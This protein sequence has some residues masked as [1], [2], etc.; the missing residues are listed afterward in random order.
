LEAILEELDISGRGFYVR[1]P[2]G[3]VYVYVPLSGGASPP[4]PLLEPSG[5]LYREDGSEFLV[6]VPPASE[7]ARSPELRGMKLESALSYVL[8]DLLATAESIEVAS[9][10]R[11]SVRLRNAKSRV[12]AGR[13]RAVFGSLEASIAACILASM[14]GAA[15]VVDEVEE[16]GDKIIRMEVLKT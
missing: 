2:G 12:L 6:L 5:V 4:K 16:G 10:E 11:V 14:Y 15:R 8:V 9:D 7:V 13:F 1:A 3:R